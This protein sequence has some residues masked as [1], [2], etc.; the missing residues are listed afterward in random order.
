MSDLLIRYEIYRFF[1]DECRAPSA[2]KIAGIVD[3]PIDEVNLAF[4]RQPS[5]GRPANVE[6][7]TMIRLA[8]LSDIHDN[9]PG[10]SRLPQVSRGRLRP[11]TPAAHR[12]PSQR[13]RGDQ[14]WQRRTA[15]VRG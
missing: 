4:R 3:L 5:F 9:L 8:L 11:F 6:L 15:R 2:E 14:S 1:A 12:S 10:S 7:E 13:R